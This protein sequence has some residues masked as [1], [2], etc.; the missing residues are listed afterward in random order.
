MKCVHYQSSPCHPPQCWTMLKSWS[1]NPGDADANRWLAVLIVV[2]D[3]QQE[4][5]C[6]AD[7]WKFQLSSLTCSS[8]EA[9]AYFPFGQ[10]VGNRIIEI[11]LKYLSSII[12]PVQRDGFCDHVGTG[13]PGHG[14]YYL[15]HLYTSLVFWFPFSHFPPLHRCLKTGDLQRHS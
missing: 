2:A 5:L 13:R 7:R 10:S 6:S 4:N 15:H 11:T 1:E 14:H 12:S 8:K 9:N 3:R